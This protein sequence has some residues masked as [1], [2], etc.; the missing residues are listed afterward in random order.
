LQENKNGN[1]FVKKINMQTFLPVYPS[2]IK[3]VNSKIGVKTI[4]NKVLYFNSGGPIYQHDEDDYQSFRYITSQMIDLKAVRQI[5]VIS[6]FKVSKESVIRWSRT[7][8]QKG[9]KG[10]FSTKKVEKRGNVLTD[11]LLL[12][13][14]G[15]L[16]QGKS[17]KEIGEELSIKPDTI[18]KGVQSGRLT[19]PVASAVTTP[20]E[21]T[22][23]E[24]S[25]ED[26]VAAMGVGC[27]NETGR[28]LAA[29]KKK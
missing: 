4:G 14:Q 15:Y 27:T 6:F 18:Q 29:V 17:L 9:A 7:Y 2:D 8:R 28:I 13:V 11:D 10:F 5:E 23:S 25:K 24:R 22:Q 3:M 26:T 16:N 20:V 12:K 21:K 1:L 19:R